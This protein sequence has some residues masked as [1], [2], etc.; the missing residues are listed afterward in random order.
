MR[1]TL[2]PMDI[3]LH[4]MEEP[5]AKQLRDASAQPGT[6]FY[7]ARSTSECLALAEQLH[8]DVVFCSS[9]PGEYRDLLAALKRRVLQLPVVV[10][11]R[12][13]EISEW[14]DA[15]D[16]GAMDYCAAPFEHQ[17]IRWMIESALIGTQRAAA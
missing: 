6:A 7:A 15:L 13:P 8:P 9:A 12:L 5:L 10:V 17:H 16:A 4:G 3:I 11:S 1:P 14:L 2:P